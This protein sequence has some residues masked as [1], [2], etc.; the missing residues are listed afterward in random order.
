MLLVAMVMYLDPKH[1]LLEKSFRGTF[2]IS[3]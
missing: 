1:I 3:H 2:L